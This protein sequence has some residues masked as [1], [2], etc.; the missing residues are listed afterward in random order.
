MIQGG[1][2]MPPRTHS[3]SSHSSYSRSSFSSSRSYSS[4]SS[5]SS[6]YSRPSRP[7]PHSSTSHSSRPSYS[8]SVQRPKTI[9]NRPRNNQPTGFR[10]VQGVRPAYHYA[11][12]HDYIFYPVAWVDQSTGTSYQAGYYDEDGYGGDDYGVGRY[13]DS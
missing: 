13:Y 2:S 12:R 11:R 7:S 9:P 4:R 8:S 3:S 6:S 1:I 5:S 10:P